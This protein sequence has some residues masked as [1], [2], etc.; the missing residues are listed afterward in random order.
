MRNGRDRTATIDA[1]TIGSGPLSFPMWVTVRIAALKACGSGGPKPGPPLQL[2]A[3]LPFRPFVVIFCRRLPQN[4]AGGASRSAA[5]AR[6]LIMGDG[7]VIGPRLCPF[8]EPAHLWGECSGLPA[9]FRLPGPCWNHSTPPPSRG[10]LS[11]RHN[12][13]PARR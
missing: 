3:I 10:L 7:V 11:L 9:G 4:I 1:R 12:C 5:M 8:V 6:G 2:S 13:D